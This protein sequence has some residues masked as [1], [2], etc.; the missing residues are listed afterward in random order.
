LRARREHWQPPGAVGIRTDKADAELD[1]PAGE[2]VAAR[3]MGERGHGDARRRRDRLA[4]LGAD[5]WAAVTDVGSSTYFDDQRGQGMGMDREAE[6]SRGL[7][8]G[9]TVE[10]EPGDSVEKNKEIRLLGSRTTVA[11]VSGESTHAT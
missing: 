10:E 9:R 3:L 8:L 11:R 1:A 4:W 6:Q 2:V 5:D 7:P